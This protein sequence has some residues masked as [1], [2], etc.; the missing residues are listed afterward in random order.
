MYLKND[1]HLLSSN[2]LHHN[3]ILILKRGI[4]YRSIFL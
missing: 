3:K 1:E 2:V 4:S